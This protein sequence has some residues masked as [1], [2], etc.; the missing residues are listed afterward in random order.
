MPFWRLYFKRTHR[1]RHGEKGT[2][3]VKKQQLQALYKG[4]EILH[5]KEGESVDEY[6]SRTLTIENKMCIHGDKLEDVAVVE[7]IL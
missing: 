7:K 3:R 6:F 5:L 4:F 1:N 2:S